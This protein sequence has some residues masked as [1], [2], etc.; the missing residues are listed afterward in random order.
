MEKDLQAS[1]IRVESRRF[2]SLSGVSHN[3]Q[4]L[5][6]RDW[7]EEVTTVL[8]NVLEQKLLSS[9]LHMVS[10]RSTCDSQDI[11]LKELHEPGESSHTC[12]LWASF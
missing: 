7:K 5:D 8:G 2:S 3:F 6:V 12:R 11:T 1:E 10:T 9:G 4:H